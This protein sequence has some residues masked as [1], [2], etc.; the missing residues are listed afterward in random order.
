MSAV[1]LHRRREGGVADLQVHDLNLQ[2]ADA[3]FGQ[4]FLLVQRISERVDP[5]VIDTEAQ[6]F[7]NRLA[8]MTDAWKL[9][10][11][12][13]PFGIV[14]PSVSDWPSNSVRR[15]V[16]DSASAAYIPAQLEEQ[17]LL[18]PLFIWLSLLSNE[19]PHCLH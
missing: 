12:M 7:S 14:S 5:A 2:L 10:N 6:Q 15:Q 8:S 16:T 19:P 18:A 9:F 17:K 3:F 1:V 11:A 4:V 13:P